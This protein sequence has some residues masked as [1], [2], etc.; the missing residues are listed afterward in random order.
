MGRAG[1]GRGAGVLVDGAMVNLG[2]AGLGDTGLTTGVIRG[3]VALA[4]GV[5][6]AGLP[7]LTG[8]VPPVGLPGLLACWPFPGI[9]FTATGGALM[10]L[11]GPAIGFFGGSLGTWATGRTRAPAGGRQPGRS[12]MTHTCLCSC[13]W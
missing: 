4:G 8:V 12:S 10:G 6:A 1:A 2:G 11:P 9:G 3:R 7:V 5:V 13:Q